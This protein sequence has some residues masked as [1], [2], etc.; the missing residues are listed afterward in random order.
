MN[1]LELRQ[2][3]LQN[4]HFLKAIF[5][6]QSNKTTKTLLLNSNKEEI[7]TLL[8]ILF[9]ITQ[10]DIPIKRKNF[11]I[12]KKS[13]RLFYLHNQFENIIKFNKILSLDLKT[14]MGLL[15]KLKSIFSILLHPL[16]HKTSEL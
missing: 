16:F 6:S 9:S 12:L 1:H 10:G 4:K 5:E 14:K 8:Q 2:S 11:E 15:F 7:D 13:N 3:I